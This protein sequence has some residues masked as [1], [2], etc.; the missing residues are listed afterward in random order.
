MQKT[1]LKLLTATKYLIK[2]L[3]RF[4][5]RRYVLGSLGNHSE[6]LPPFIIKGGKH[7]YI[8]DDVIIAH[9]AWL[10]AITQVGDH[11]YNPVVKI[12]EGTH[13]GHF[14]HLS[15]NNNVY[16]GP[17]VLI[18]DRVF[19]TDHQH[20]FKDPEIPVIRQGINSLGPVIIEEGCWIGEN[21]SIMPNVVIGKHAVIGANAVVTKSIPSFTVA[22]G[23]PAKVIKRYNFD[24][25]KWENEIA[26]A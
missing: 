4:Y 16:I 22:T 5:C 14:F 25:K 17:H 19:I 1:I 3:I 21:V 18:A 2:Q 24:T 7:I 12:E 6:V 26:D 8:G 23:S 11:E 20:N 13:V 15:C 9:C 10:N